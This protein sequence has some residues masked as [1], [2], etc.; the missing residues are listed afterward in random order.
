M[1]LTTFAPATGDHD[2]R[3]LAA[4]L[5]TVPAAA[6]YDRDE[7]ERLRSAPRRITRAEAERLAIEESLADGERTTAALPRPD[8]IDGYPMTGRLSEGL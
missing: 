4:F 3:G 7:Y 6:D 8:G 2:D 5:A 1:S